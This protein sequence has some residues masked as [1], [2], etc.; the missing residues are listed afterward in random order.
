ME[1]TFRE[2]V[3]DCRSEGTTFSYGICIGCIAGVAD[4]V[5]ALLKEAHRTPGI[6]IPFG[7]TFGDLAKVLVKY[8]D[9]HREQLYR[10]RGWGVLLV[11]KD[12][13]PCTSESK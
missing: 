4:W 13:F 5:P 9:E 10:D 7:V 11:L 6:C 3:T 1:P 2:F 12:T 8:G